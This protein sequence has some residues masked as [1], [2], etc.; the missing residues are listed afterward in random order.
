[1]TGDH[2]RT[3]GDKTHVDHV[4]VRTKTREIE[5]RRVL[6][7]QQVHHRGPAEML[8]RAGVIRG[9]QKV[10]SPPK[11]KRLTFIFSR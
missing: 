5:R 7:R 1:M 9:R 2:R 4:A 8:G 3:L 6:P 10:A 11:G